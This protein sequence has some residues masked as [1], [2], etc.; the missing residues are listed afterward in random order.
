MS[1]LPGVLDEAQTLA[2]DLRSKLHD[3]WMTAADEGARWSQTQL[4]D[5]HALADDLSS[6]ISNHRNAIRS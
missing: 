4:S 5:M 2:D 6:R 1:D 3:A